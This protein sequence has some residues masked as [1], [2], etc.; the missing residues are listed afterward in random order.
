MLTYV[1]NSDSTPLMPCHPARARELVRKGRAYWVRRD[2]IKLTAYREAVKQEVTVGIDSGAESIGLAAV[3]KRSK[4]KPKVLFRAVVK[5]RPMT[6]IKQLLDARRSYRR[7]RRSRQGYRQPWFSPTR[8]VSLSAKLYD[9]EGN[10]LYKIPV[11]YGKQLTKPDKGGKPQAKRI[12]GNRFKLL[13]GRKPPEHVREKKPGKKDI[14]VYGKDGRL[15]T[16]YD[17]KRADFE[18]I[19]K[20][21]LG[22]SHRHKKPIATIETENGRKV[23]RL[24]SKSA[25]GK[26]PKEVTPNF[27]PPFRKFGQKRKPPGWLSPSALSLKDAHIRGLAIVAKYVPVTSVRLEVAAF[28]PQKLNEPAI[29]GVG[30]QKPALYAKQN[31]KDFILAR[32]G[33]KCVYC[34]KSGLGENSVPLTQDHIVPRHPK[35]G[36]PG[37]DSISNLVAACLDCQKE[38]SNLS[39]E[40]YLKMKPKEAQRIRKYIAS[41]AKRNQA[42]T[43]AAHVGQIKNR[44][45][46]ELGASVTYGY[47]TKRDRIAMK[48]PK[49]HDMDAIAIA[50]RGRKIARDLPG[51]RSYYARRFPAGKSSRRQKY[52]A[53]PLAKKK[54]H[55]AGYATAWVG[56]D[57][58]HRLVHR[59]GVNESAV[60]SS[61]D[62]ISLRDVVKVQDGRVGYVMKIGKSVVTLSPYPTGKKGRFTCSPNKIIKVLWRR[63]GL[64]E[65][66]SG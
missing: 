65:Q 8:R 39:L 18:A 50:A 16:W 2:T 23:I 10:F 32:D 44:L 33:W 38:K 66:L 60:I 46:K 6:E 30:Y 14:L 56:K 51:L 1:L 17:P 34:G 21:L 11:A 27:M 52:K 4:H 40:E 43:E 64:M 20:R 35:S 47:I 29:E 7:G 57:K 54:E 13:T 22:L 24:L 61:G 15:I 19:E 45:I 26:V 3:A 62:K 42:L 9:K 58:R 49:T 36:K 37:T 12:G 5:A 48:L 25:E 41:L 31:R 28:D 59:I 55:Q 63:K 53:N